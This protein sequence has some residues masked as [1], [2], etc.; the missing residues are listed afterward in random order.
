ML[1][2]SGEPIINQTFT[3]YLFIVHT[4][5]HMWIS[6]QTQFY[7]RHVAYDQRGMQMRP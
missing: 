3:F 6:M 7:D 2:H 4:I 1:L 5:I